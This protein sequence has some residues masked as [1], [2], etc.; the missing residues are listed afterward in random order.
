MTVDLSAEASSPVTPADPSPIWRWV[1]IGLRAVG[2]AVAAWGGLL[3][4]AY[5][6]FITAFRIGP[7][8][9][10]VA[11]PLAIVGNAALIWFA[12]RVS[13]SK[14]LGL[15]PGLLWIAVSFVWSSR[16]TEGDLVLYDSNWVGPAYLL[17]G[18]ATIGVCAYRMIVPPRRP[19]L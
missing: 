7:T 6:A 13:G 19:Y 2:A 16:S 17:T 15:L 11:L 4:A 3:L 14:F 12:H 5:G 10:P 9:V 1:D 8:L 18:A